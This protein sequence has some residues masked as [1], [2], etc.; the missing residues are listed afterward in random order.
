MSDAREETGGQPVVGDGGHPVPAEPEAF[1]ATPPPK[2][3]QP[4]TAAST[5]AAA[6]AEPAAADTPAPAAGQDA[7]PEQAEKPEPVAQPDPVAAAHAAPAPAAH[8]SDPFAVAAAAGSAPGTAAGAG[9]AGTPPYGFPAAPY[10]GYPGYGAPVQPRKKRRPNPLVATAVLTALLAGGV[11][12]GIGAWIADRDDNPSSSGINAPQ[13]PVDPAS[14]NRA[15]ESVAGIAAKAL[16]GTVT[17]KTKSGSGQGAQE[18]TGA[19]FVLDDQGHILTNNHVVSLAANGGDLTVTFQDGTTVP[20]KIVGRAE[21][22]DL[23]V[24]KVDGVQNLKPLPL[25]D[26]SNVAVGDAVLAI[27]SPYGLD[28]TVTTG[29]VSAKN[30]PVAS[31]DQQQTSYM[32]ALQT[33]ASINPGNSGGPL[34][35][36]QGRVIGVNSAIRSAGSGADPFGGQQSAGSIGLGFAIPVNQAKWVADTLIK[37]GKPVYAQ[38]GVIPDPEYRGPGARIRQNTVQGQA[39]VTPGGPADQAGLKAGDVIT[40][41]GDRPVTGYEELFSEIWSHK[42]GEKVKVTYLRDGKEA[43]TELTLGQREGDQSR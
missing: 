5:P 24:V 14:V 32:N 42:P 13:S 2:P 20:G 43:T 26:S 17:I 35:D 40:K 34:L 25:G 16:P 9:G 11:G 36:A 12:G 39:P 30:R 21:G 31:G 29:I 38:V 6:P 8:D 27:G 41:L 28:G 37:T 4:P 10:P 23:A 15:P 1:P 33:D 18:G 22:Y 19:G 7:P 3:A